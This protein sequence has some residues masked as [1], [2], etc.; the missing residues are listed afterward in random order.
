M[1]DFST[2]SDGKQAENK[3]SDAPSTQIKHTADVS[4]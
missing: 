2:D 4:V 3:Q 1:A